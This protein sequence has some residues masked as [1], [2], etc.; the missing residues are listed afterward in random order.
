MD[1]LLLRVLA[2]LA[3]LAIS[4]WLFVALSR[5][6]HPFELEW[7]EGGMLAHVERL[8]AGLPLYAEPSLEFAAFPYPPLFHWVAAASTG[9]VGT[10]FGALRLVSILATVYTLVLLA[11]HGT[12]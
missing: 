12:R 8:V 6:G 3:F 5:V 2:T 9:V 1:R 11:L 10:G 7:Q 4:T